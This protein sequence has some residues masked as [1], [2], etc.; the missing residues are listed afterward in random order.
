MVR[1]AFRRVNGTTDKLRGCI[2][3]RCLSPT[4]AFLLLAPLGLAAHSV[5]LQEEGLH[6]KAAKPVDGQEQNNFEHASLS[7]C[8]K[9]SSQ[10]GLSLGPLVRLDDHGSSVFGLSPLRTYDALLLVLQ[11]SL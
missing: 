10:L 4:S 1:L 8:S 7:R 6:S 3:V 9:D 5:L 2:D 11:A